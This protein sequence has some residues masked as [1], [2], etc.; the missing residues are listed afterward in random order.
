MKSNQPSPV[1]PYLG[2]LVGLF[3]IAVSAP[4]GWETLAR[5]ESIQSF[6]DCHPAEPTG[7]AQSDTAAVSPSPEAVG[8]VESATG[9]VPAFGVSLPQS[10]SSFASQALASDLSAEDSA[11]PS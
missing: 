6:L 11:A 7:P 8:S 4:R 3:A 2:I 5:R 9:R 10:D 1:W